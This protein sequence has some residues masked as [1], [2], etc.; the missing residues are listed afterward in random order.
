[1]SENI[2]QEDAQKIICTTWL[3]GKIVIPSL[4][5]EEIKSRYDAGEIDIVLFPRKKKKDE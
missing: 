1:M 3:N 2:K 4:T 5:L